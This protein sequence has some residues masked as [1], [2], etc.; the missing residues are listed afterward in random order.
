MNRRD[1]LGGHVMQ[2]ASDTGHRMAGETLGGRN[3]EVAAAR[4]TG[5]AS[6]VA[7]E[8]DGGV[9]DAQTVR[10]IVVDDD[11]EYARMVGLMLAKAESCRFDV[12]TA[13]S[14]TG[15]IEQV[16]SCAFDAA[17][18]DLGLPDSRGPDT[19]AQLREAAP[20]LPIVILSAVDDEQIIY[21]GMQ[22][23]AQDYLV[24]GPLVKQ[25]LPRA[26]VYAIE[27][28]RAE[29]GIR[30]FSRRLLAVREEEKKALSSALHHE[31]GSVA[32]GLSAYL[33]EVEKHIVHNRPE[34]AVKSL[35]E[36]RHLVLSCIRRLKNLAV[37]LR[38]PDLD[39]LGL[40][41]AVGEYLSH[42]ADHSDLRIRFVGNVDEG[43]VVPGV[44]TTLFRCVQECVTNV[45]RHAAASTVTVRL[46]TGK[47]LVSLTVGDD[48]RGFDPERITP[49]GGVHLGILAMREMVEGHG[50]TFVVSSPGEG[51]EVGIEIPCNDETE[52]P[53]EEGGR[54]TQDDG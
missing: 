8:G 12:A 11:V 48:G 23:G 50:G 44:A 20:A 52:P 53:G 54:T 4:S 7:P 19:V 16:R 24:K 47:R 30:L 26:L 36:G 40:R 38:P 18:L 3:V 22:K 51:T 29:Q 34:D 14:L 37:E 49:G 25:L 45:V 21:A 42:L 28:K 39:V 35:Q 17:V 46:Q 27:R 1:G 15:G 9:D 10:V 13:H 31:V 41:A 5:A 33:S 43:M 2:A 6:S 32:V